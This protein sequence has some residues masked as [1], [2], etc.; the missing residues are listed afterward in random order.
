M[1]RFLIFISIF[2]VVF[3][4]Y[5][6]QTFRTL[7]KS[8]WAHGAYVVFFL[9]IWIYFLIRMSNYQPSAAMQAGKA[10]AG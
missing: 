7:F 1:S 6:F 9:G 3:A 2:Y 4:V 10:I 5:G 8:Q